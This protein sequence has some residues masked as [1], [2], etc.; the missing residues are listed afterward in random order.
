MILPIQHAIRAR[1][2]AVLDSLYG[3]HGD[4]FPIRVVEVPPSRALGDNKQAK[5][6]GGEEG[7]G[8]GY[9]HWPILVTAGG[10]DAGLLG[11]SAGQPCDFLYKDFASWGNV[12]G[13]W[14]L[15][16]VAP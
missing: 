5:W 6:M 2:A 12:N 3:L 11:C 8:H 10:T 14:G 9:G 16:R 15:L 7:M 4:Q 1:V 13:M